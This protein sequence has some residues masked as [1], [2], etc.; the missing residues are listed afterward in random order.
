MQ[1][2]YTQHPLLRPLVRC[3]TKPQRQNLIVLIVAV[4][5]ARTF[6]QRQLVLYLALV[7]ST[8]SCYRR[9]ERMLDWSPATWEAFS[10]AWVRAVLAT[11]APGN[12]MLVLLI[13]WT[14]HR[15]RCRS[16]W[17]ML[18]VGGRA[19][20]LAFWLAPM[21]MG[22]P[23]SQRAFEDEAVTQ[24]RAWLPKSRRAVLIGDRGFRGR[25]RMQ[26]LKRLGFRF[27]LRVTGD[28][29]I[30]VRV[31]K[32]WQ[33]VAL[34][35][36]TPA[37]GERRQ[38]RRV[39][40]G[41][42]KQ[43]GALFVNLVAVRQELAA[44]KAVKTNKGKPTGKTVEETVWFLASDLPLRIDIAALYFQRMQIEE[45][46]RDAKALLGLEQERTKAPWER[47][48]SLMWALTVG[49][50][51]DLQQGDEALQAPPRLP[52]CPKDASHVAPA[53][54]P[55]YRAE[56]ATREG[57]HRLVVEAVLGSSPFTRELHAMAAKSERMKARPQVRDRRRSTPALR[58][59][60]KRESRLHVYA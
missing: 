25:D 19:V 34:R 21:T 22:G 35:E 14:L 31:G 51:L 50:A 43:G 49:L 39:R 20:P 6:I 60:T 55:D 8:S 17:V 24:L 15:D 4:Q 48:R 36:V 56:S 28:T 3:L 53:E 40:Y 1:E 29:Q 5:F 23:G 32:Q 37:L 44:P 26:F 2:E 45:S 47:L 59:R 58:R 13:D 16:L 38:W 18:P 11:F 7:I 46:F 33:W 10:R 57:L 42:S 52:L 27:V 9:L 30:E 12:G 41:K 54:V